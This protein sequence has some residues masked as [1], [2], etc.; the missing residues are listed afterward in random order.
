[1]DVRHEVTVWEV[2]HPERPSIRVTSSFSPN[3]SSS[4]LVVL[5]GY[6][7]LV[8]PSVV[9]PKERVSWFIDS[10]RQLVEANHAFELKASKLT[11]NS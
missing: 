9:I 11:D 3:P 2:D 7:E 5:T 10:L 1:M 8:L 6:G 4:S